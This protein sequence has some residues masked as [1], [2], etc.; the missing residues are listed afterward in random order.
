[1]SGLAMYGTTVVTGHVATRP[2]AA[3]REHTTAAYFA[4][5]LSL[6]G[7]ASRSATRAVNDFAAFSAPGSHLKSTDLEWCSQQLDLNQY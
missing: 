2:L 4:K 1:M 7:V 5:S 6:M 3:G